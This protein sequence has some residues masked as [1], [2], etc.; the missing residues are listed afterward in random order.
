MESLVINAAN[1]LSEIEAMVLH[2]LDDEEIIMDMLGG[3]ASRYGN[4]VRIWQLPESLRAD[5]SIA[6]YL[7]DYESIADAV[8]AAREM[9]C[10]L[11]GPSTVV[12]SMSSP[13]QPEPAFAGS[14][15][16]ESVCYLLRGDFQ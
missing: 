14:G 9:E 8:A 6:T 4:V 10:P 7:I 12:V 1:R 11:A 2:G 15:Q 16:D 13:A 3:F 5:R